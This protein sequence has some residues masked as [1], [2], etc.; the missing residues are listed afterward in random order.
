MLHNLTVCFASSFHSL[1]VVSF[2][3]IIIF[4]SFVVDHFAIFILSVLCPNLSS[5]ST[6]ASKAVN[7]PP[8]GCNFSSFPNVFAVSTP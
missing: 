3:T 8:K 4:I 5:V 6:S 7:K 1:P 2:S